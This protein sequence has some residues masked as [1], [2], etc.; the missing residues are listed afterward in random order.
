VVG[1]PPPAIRGEIHSQPARNG[2]LDGIRAL[3]ALSVLSFHVWLYRVGN[4]P[5]TRT[6][7]FDKA[8]FEASLGLI[9]FFVLSGFLLYR[10]FARAALRGGEPVPLGRYALRRA[11]RIVPAYYA[12]VLGC[13]LLYSALGYSTLVPSAGHLPLF[14]VFGQN[15]SMDTVMK[16]NPVTWSLCVEA[17]FYVFLPLLGLIAF[18]L[19]PKRAGRQAGVLIGLVVLNIGWNAV[20]HDAGWGALASKALPTYIGYFAFGMLFAM[21]VEWRSIR[22]ERGSLSRASS[23]ALMTTGFSLVAATAYL[24]ETAGSFTAT[25]I[26]LGNLPAALGFALLIA[27][28][29]AGIGPAVSWLGARPLAALGVVSYGIYLWHLPLIL[30]LREMGLL[31][32]A[33]ASR[34]A[35]VLL[36][37]IGAATLSWMLVE[38]P[39]LGLV[40]A[41][42]RRDRAV[43]ARRSS[44][45]SRQ[46]REHRRPRTARIP[47]V[48]RSGGFTRLA[49]PDGLARRPSRRSGHLA[50]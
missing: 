20:L 34:L 44:A 5:G 32:A 22:G 10:P 39:I 15:Y 29:A 33:F 13:L 36:F 17:A 42:R 27:A 21:W 8:L 12:S 46:R 47:A 41:R 24:H 23:A 19:G 48:L 14:A 9:C 3:A 7:L 38:R 30:A 40:V 35:L 2:T 11:A 28:G 50:P 18:L 26:L 16:I 31:P 25:W 37:T 45:P 4:P 1:Q 43:G 6:T 49:R